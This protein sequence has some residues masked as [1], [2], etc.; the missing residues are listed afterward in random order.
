[1]PCLLA[2]SVLYWSSFRFTHKTGYINIICKLLYVRH[3]GHHPRYDSKFPYKHAWRHMPP[4]YPQYFIR[5][6]KCLERV[7][8]DYP[9]TNTDESQSSHIQ[10]TIYVPE[11]TILPSRSSTI[12]HF[13]VPR[14]LKGSIAGDQEIYGYET[15]ENAVLHTSGSE[16][17]S[18][19]EHV[20]HILTTL[21]LCGN[22]RLCTS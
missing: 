18:I 22:H 3:Q 9:G 17:A 2:L 6:R 5:I 8:R 15:Q 19:L 16:Q 1:M 21:A 20:K 7:K 11:I 14:P 4:Q 10:L 13:S 12:M